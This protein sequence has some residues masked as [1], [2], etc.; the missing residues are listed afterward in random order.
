MMHRALQKAVWS[1]T[2]SAAMRVLSSHPIVCQEKTRPG[3][4]EIQQAYDQFKYDEVIFLSRQALNAVPPP[5]QTEQVQIYMY[6]AYAHISLGQKQEAQK[7]FEMALDLDPNLKLD[8]I[9]VSPKIISIFEEVKN[10]SAAEGIEQRKLISESMLFKKTLQSNAAWRSLI[11]PGWGQFYKG[12]RA[13][14]ITV[15]AAHTLNVGTLVFAHLRMQQAHD[16]YL[17]AR[18]LP[19]IESTYDRY[20]KFYKLRKYFALSTAAV[21]LYAHLDAALTDPSP[22]KTVNTVAPS[23]YFGPN[24]NDDSIGFVYVVKF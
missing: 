9:Y 6:L 10:A 2:C 22:E 1:I 15:L 11:L 21:W 8:P 17:K 20:N 23:S 3:I 18:D 14:G 16:D 12:Q 13:K 4:M 24:M 19:T 7:D 5:V